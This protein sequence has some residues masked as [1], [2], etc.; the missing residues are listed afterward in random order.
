MVEKKELEEL[1]VRFQ[2]ENQQLE[3]ITVQKQRLLIEKSEIENALKELEKSK[4]V[5]K[6]VGPIIIKAKPTELKKELEEKKE[7]IEIRIKGL[8]KSEEKL[9]EMVEKDK[10][11]IEKLLPSLQ[12]S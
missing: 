5:Y 9:K 12:K 4:E 11:K 7:E 10:E 3:A 1:L 6:I 2:V 8:E